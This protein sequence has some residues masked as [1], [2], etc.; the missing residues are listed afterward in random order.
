VCR[1]RCPAYNSHAP[2][3]HLFPF[4]YHIF[5]HYLISGS[6]F[7]KK[8]VL[9]IKHV[10]GF[11][12]QLFSETYKYL[13]V[14][15]NERDMVKNVYWSSCKTATRYSC[16]V[17]MKLEIS[18]HTAKNIQISNFTKIRPLGAVL[19]RADRQRD[20]A[21]SRFSKFCERA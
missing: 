11:C 12:L 4:D 5:P 19:F 15:R 8:K 20:E 13:I 3:F 7:E 17:L 14:R 9:N 16:Q 2:Y 18:R 10:F 6:I 1:F 21:N